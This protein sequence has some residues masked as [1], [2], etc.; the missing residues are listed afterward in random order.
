MIEFPIY[1]TGSKNHIT[2][3]IIIL[4]S[5]I[6]ILHL[7]FPTMDRSVFLILFLILI[8]YFAL[9]KDKK[10]SIGKIYLDNYQI[11]VETETNNFQVELRDID[12]LELVYSGY[13]G[14][15]LRGDFIGPYHRFSGIDNYIQIENNSS[16]FKYRFLVENSN[17]EYDLM[18][19]VKNW[20]TLGYDMSNIKIN[21]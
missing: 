13:H 3:Y 4:G 16:E 14:K 15:R 11:K 21:R 8:F 5:A 9:K 17:E 1:N 7:L 19:L 10:E 2:P 6:I 12:K 18:E 20:K